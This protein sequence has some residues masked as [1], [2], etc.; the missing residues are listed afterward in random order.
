MNGSAKV[1]HGKH[2][3][4]LAAWQVQ[5]T[6]VATLVTKKNESISST[7]PPFREYSVFLP[8]FKFKMTGSR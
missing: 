5:S 4:S 8:D 6:R 1:H 7:G 3:G 2:E